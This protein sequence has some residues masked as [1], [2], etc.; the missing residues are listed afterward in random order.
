MTQ[1]TIDLNDTQA[2]LEGVQPAMLQ[3]V[4]TPPLQVKE[5]ERVVAWSR[6]ST[7]KTPVKES[8]RYRG[9]VVPA[10]LLAIPDAACSSKFQRLLQATVYDLADAKFAEYTKERMMETEMPVG[11]LSLDSILSYWAEEKQRQLIDGEKII[12]WLKQSKTFAALNDKQKVGWLREVPKIA[13]PGYKMQW[14]KK[15]A[16]AVVAKLH[17]E[18]LEH[19]VAVFIATRCNNIMTLESQEKGL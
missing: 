2:L 14:Q 8:E 12:A 9:T 10:N 3:V 6:R 7:E 15:D 13:A 16:A 1:T 17:D 19:P 11:L 4:S 18:E 5:T